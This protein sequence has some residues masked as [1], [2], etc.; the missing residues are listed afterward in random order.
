MENFPKEII[1]T[2]GNFS[3]SMTTPLTGFSLQ[4]LIW[5]FFV[6]SSSLSYAA[7][8]SRNLQFKKKYFII[9]IQNKEFWKSL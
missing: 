1:G 5:Q 7:C 9:Y 8:F 2:D 4:T 3:R 6:Q